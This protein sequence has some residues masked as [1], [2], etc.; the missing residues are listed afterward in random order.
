MITLYPTDPDHALILGLND[1][2]ENS[3]RTESRNGP[4][5]RFKTTVTTAW[6]PGFNRI[7]TDPLRDANPFLHYIESFWMLAGRE[8]LAVVAKLAANMANYS[9]DGVTLHG[10]YGYRWRKYFGHD[11]IADI[12]NEL[13]ANRETRRCVMQMWDGVRDFEKATSGGKDLPCNTAIFFDPQG[14]TLNMTVTNRSNDMVWGAFGANVV[15]MSILHEYIASRTGF[16][17]GTY[18]QMSNNLHLYLDNPVTKKV[19]DEVNQTYRCQPRTVGRTQES[20]FDRLSCTD[21]DFVSILG[22]SLAQ[23]MS[24]ES[25]SVNTSSPVWFLNLGLL[26][27]AFN[28]YKQEGPRSAVDYLGTKDRTQWSSVAIDWL[29]RRPSY[30]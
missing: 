11:Q 21:T 1:L 17:V 5:L 30:K 7:S 6:E 15:H 26:C 13:T 2:K 8:D 3:V 23:F 16:K 14:D 12:I 29:K 19:Y 10:A 22:H 24:G 9:D 18:Y 25:V 27:N 4:V 20:L 28:A